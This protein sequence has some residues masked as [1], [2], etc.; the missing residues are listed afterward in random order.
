MMKERKHITIDIV[1]DSIT[2]GLNHCGSD[3]TYT[4]QY[5][6]MLSE[7]Y[8]AAAVYRYDGIMH[9]ALL[10][11]ESFEGPIGVNDGGGE[12]RID[13]IRNGIG[14]NTVRRAIKR[15]D[16]FTG[17]LANGRH[18]DITV[19]MFGINDALKEDASK[20]VTPERFAED[21]REL[22]QSFIKT[23]RGVIAI[24]SATTNGPTL[25]EYVER[26]EEV[27]AECGALYIDLHRVWQEHYREALPN[28]G[29]GDWLSNSPNDSCHPSVKGAHVIARTLFEHIS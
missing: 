6:K 17:G 2:W 15:I 29:F 26:T 13:V 12:V 19:F 9:N 21:Y 20:Y 23:E 8:P 5:A 1:G 4:A 22:I 11:M 27:A 18:A 3:E 24:M 28:F 7:K 14:G 16:D 25:G 10:P